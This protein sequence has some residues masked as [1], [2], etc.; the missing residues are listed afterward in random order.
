MEFPDLGQQCSVQACQMLDFLPMKCDACESIYCKDHFAYSSHSCE[1][2]YLKDVQVPVCPLC[3][4]P[5][6]VKRGQLPDIQVGQH[7]DNDCQD[8]RAQKKRS[9]V[10]TNRCT[11]KGCKQKELIPVLCSD[12]KLNFCLKHR[13]PSDHKCDPRAARIPKSLQTG[14]ID[15]QV[16]PKPGTFASFF[17]S[18]SNSGAAARRLPTQANVSEVHGNL[19]EDEALARALQESLNQPSSSARPVKAPGGSPPRSQQEIEDRMLAEAIAASEQDANGGGT[20]GH[21]RRDNCNLS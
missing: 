6:P 12:C 13:H 19:T 14:Q 10:F 4:L 3:S 20:G 17:R 9:T 11:L 18:S 16:T 15:K 1:K 21:R 5:I 8:S 2:S 7:I